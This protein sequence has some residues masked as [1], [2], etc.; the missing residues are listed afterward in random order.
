MVGGREHSLSTYL[1]AWAGFLLGAAAVSASIQANYA[2]ATMR[3]DMARA[4]VLVIAALLALLASAGGWWSFTLARRNAADTSPALRLAA[5][6]SVAF[7]ALMAAVIVL[8]AVAALVY[9]GCET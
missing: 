7:A 3:C 8:H 1:R 4:P 2:I 6:V 9:A 5:G